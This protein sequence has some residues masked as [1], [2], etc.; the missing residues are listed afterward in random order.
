LPG[1]GISQAREVATA[2]DMMVDHHVIALGVKK[3]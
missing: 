2:T 1:S 3:L